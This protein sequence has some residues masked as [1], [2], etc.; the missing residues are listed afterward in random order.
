M[1]RRRRACIVASAADTADRIDRRDE[2][3]RRTRTRR[4]GIGNLFGLLFLIRH[5]EFLVVVA[6]IVLAI[7][8]YRRSR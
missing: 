8:L 1:R 7:Y 4:Y 3:V 6:V 5:P 2:L